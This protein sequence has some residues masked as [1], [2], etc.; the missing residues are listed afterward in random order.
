MCSSSKRSHLHYW[1]SCM[2]GVGA[3]PL[4]LTRHSP[5]TSWTACKGDFR[6]GF[7]YSQ[8]LLPVKRS[9]PSALLHPPMVEHYLQSERAAGRILGPL[10]QS[11]VL[12]LHTSR[13][14]VV[15]KGHMPGKWRLITDLSFP[16]GASVN[17]GIDPE[18]CSLQYTSVERVARVAQQ[19]GPHALLAKVDI[20]SAYRLVPVH[21]DDRPLLGL[22]WNGEYFVDAMLPFGLRLAP[23]IFT[24]VADALEWCARQRGSIPFIDY[25]L[26]NLIIVGP[27]Y[28]ELC[29]R[30]LAILEAECDALGV[31]LASKKREGLSTQLTFL[32]IQIDT[33]TGQLSLPPEKLLCLKRKVNRWLIRNVCRKSELE[34]LIGTLQY[35]G[36][37]IHPGR[38]FARWLIH[39]LKCARRSHYHIQLNAHIKADLLWWKAF[40]ASWNGIAFFSP[41]PGSEIEFTSDA[42]GSWAWS[43]SSWWQFQWPD[44]N[45]RDIAFK[46]LFAVIFSAALWGQYWRGER[47]RGYSDNQAVTMM[48]ASHTS[49]E[50]HLMH[51]LRCLFFIEAENHFT[52]SVTHISGET[53]VLA[54]DLSRNC[55]SSFLQKSPQSSPLPTPILSSLPDLLLN[56]TAM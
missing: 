40:A 24:A 41:P 38:S 2:R 43:G 44:G 35:A 37:V 31:P 10:D 33:A 55:L 36:K 53:N 51:L 16:E 50:P 49:K 29:S 11:A 30:G 34:S 5:P 25:Y 17:D 22:V 45:N 23:K 21:L 46:E 9:I 20:K 12:G 13:M 39:L 19:W 47:V 7:N 3:S 6:I 54:D 15:P 52:L 18:L 8:P 28:S 56:S 32:G 1:T 27:P 42:L 14:D 4:T 48:L 26:N